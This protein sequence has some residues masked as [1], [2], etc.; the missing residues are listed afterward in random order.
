M[1]LTEKH[2]CVSK[3]I[4]KLEPS[5]HSSISNSQTPQTLAEICS[6]TLT[7]HIVNTYTIYT[8]RIWKMRDFY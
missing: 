7:D 8:Y 4:H 3:I 1:F 5:M 2:Q 6:S